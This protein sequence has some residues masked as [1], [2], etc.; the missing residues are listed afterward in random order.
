VLKAL[1]DRQQNPRN[2]D[3]IRTTASTRP[4]RSRCVTPTSP[5]RHWSDP[6]GNCVSLLV[7]D[8]DIR[9]IN[10]ATGEGIEHAALRAGR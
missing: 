5:H 10:A 2:S 1:P 8:L 9:I 4:A 3:R 6:A 7:Q